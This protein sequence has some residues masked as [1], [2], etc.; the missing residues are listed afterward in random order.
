MFFLFFFLILPPIKHKPMTAGAE[1]YM[2]TIIAALT[3]AMTSVSSARATQQ[4]M[5]SLINVYRTAQLTDKERITL[6]HDILITNIYI[7]NTPGDE[8]VPLNRRVVHYAS[9]GLAL[10][11]RLGDRLMAAS[12]CI[13][14]AGALVLDARY[15][16]T[17][18]YHEQAL[19][20]TRDISDSRYSMAIYI[21]MIDAAMRE[22]KFVE[23]AEMNHTLEQK[24]A[25]ANYLH[26]RYVAKAYWCTIYRQIHDYDTAREHLERIY[27]ECPPDMWPSSD[28]QLQYLCNFAY[29]YLDEGDLDKA[30]TYA[31]S[32]C[33]LPVVYHVYHCLADI[34][35]AKVALGRG[36]CEAALHHLDHGTELAEL[37]GDA[38]L[39]TR[40]RNTR[41][42]IFM[43]QGR[44]DES[45]RAA[46]LA[47][48]TD[49]TAVD[50]APAIAR[51]IAMAYMRLGR[52]NDADSFLDKYSAL[53]QQRAMF[54]RTIDIN[55]ANELSVVRIRALK[56]ERRLVYTLIIS[57]LAFVTIIAIFGHYR[58][59]KKR[60]IIRQQMMIDGAMEER[61][62]LSD[63]LH[64]GLNRTLSAARHYLTD[65]QQTEAAIGMIDKAVGEVRAFTRHVMPDALRQYGLRSAVEDICAS[66]PQVK[67]NAHG[68]N[69]RYDLHFE[70]QVYLS[71]SE[72]ISNAVRHANATEIMV[73]L[74]Q[75]EQ[76]V[77]FTVG[78][79]GCGFDPSKITDD[80]GL[81]RL[82]KR[83][84]LYNGHVNI[85]SAPGDKTEITI[86]LFIKH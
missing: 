54:H 53:M 84:Q 41:A 71:I 62:A 35:K 16:S 73:Y 32:I 28:M 7:F 64:D 37:L 34:V 58:M 67:L 10:A 83:A 3:V 66:T 12:F 61:A 47:W 49:S 26:G 82:R 33:D 14:L 24:A 36:D 39:R 11:D 1:R 55:R 9:E 50:M 80:S 85:D 59:R 17:R 74:W 22:G 42:E 15:D 29:I 57:T 30:E 43:I 65:G 51:N 31:D 60:L 23:A 69:L 5:D 2:I 4:R 81:G 86:E 79:N 38:F 72:L 75:N 44:Y 18:Y 70:M 77:V 63:L 76:S 56:N 27:R 20:Y 68:D 13:N 52:I 40:V 21:N 6:I 8:G 46:L 48:D 25:E 78:D 19:E 45:L